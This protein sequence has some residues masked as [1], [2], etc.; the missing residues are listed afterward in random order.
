MK[1]RFK[2]EIMDDLDEQGTAGSTRVYVGDISIS[3][4]DLIRAIAMVIDRVRQDELALYICTRMQKGVADIIDVLHAVD[5]ESPA[6]VVELNGKA[7][8]HYRCIVSVIDWTTWYCLQRPSTSDPSDIV[9]LSIVES[10]D[11]D[12]E[13]ILEAV[14]G[15]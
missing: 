5:D 14:V 2:V 8:R 13:R 11:D 9:E 3:E 12:I 7:D 15:R 4:R 1:Y 10:S 6:A